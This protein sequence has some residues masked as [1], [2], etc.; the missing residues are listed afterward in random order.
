APPSAAR[1]RVLRQDRLDLDAALRFNA[2]CL[3]GEAPWIW[4]TSGPMGRGYVSPV[5]LPDDGPCLACLLGHF[6][7][8]SPLPELYDEL[9]AHARA[10]GVIGPSPFPP[11]GEAILSSLADWKAERLASSAP[12]VF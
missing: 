1:P 11:H 2:E 12:A 6:R 3:G 10:G 7:R 4:V 8:L 9:I 5:F